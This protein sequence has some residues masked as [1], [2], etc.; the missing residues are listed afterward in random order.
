MRRLA[1]AA[2][3]LLATCVLPGEPSNHVVFAFAFTQP[4]RV[5]MGRPD[6]MRPHA[7]SPQISATANGEPLTNP[8]YRLESSNPSI[9]RVDSSGRGLQGVARGT[10]S[11]R[12]VLATALGAPDTT[13][14]V[15]VV[16]SHVTIEAPT[17]ILTK[18][19]QKDSLTAYASD[20][21]YRPVP[22]VTFTWASSRPGVG[23][24]SSAGLVTAVDEGNTMITAE[25]DGVTGSISLTVV[26]AAVRVQVSPKI[27][28]LRTSGRDRQFQAFAY[29][30]T[31]TR[32]LPV[33]VLWQSTVPAVATVDTAGRAIAQNAGTTKIIAKVGLVAD[34]AILVLK[35]VLRFVVVS[36]GLDTL[37]AIDDTSRFVAQALDSASIGI[38][39][40]PSVTWATADSAI[41]TV[42]QTGLVRARINGL[43]LVTA[44]SAGQPGSAVV[45]V[46]QEVSKAKISEDTLSLMG[47]GA[48]GR[49]TAAGVDRN[50]YPVPAAGTRFLWYSRLGLVATVDTGGLV[51]AHGDG[52]TTVLAQP[53]N[54]GAVDTATV[55]VTGAPQRLIAFDSP[56]GIEVVRV[57]GTLGT[58]LVNGNS[59][60]YYDTYMPQDPAWSVD[61][62]RVAYAAQYI[63]YYYGSYWSIKVSGVDGST[64]GEPYTASWFSSG[65]TWSPDGTKL[66][67]SSD[68][69]GSVASSIYTVPAA[70]GSVTNLTSSSTAHDYKPAWSPDGAKIAF[71]SNRDGNYEIYVMNV[72][73]SGVARLTND[74]GPDAEPAWSP[75]GSQLAFMRT[76][77][78][79]QD[80]WLMN[81]DGSGET[82]L[83][84]SATGPTVVDASPAW[85]PDGSQVVFASICS[86]CS[87]SDLYVINRDGTGLRR[88]TTNAGAGHPAWRTT[89]PLTPPQSGAAATPRRRRG[90]TR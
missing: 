44:S 14:D 24:I 73:G 74:P 67:F 89:A 65:P 69:A 27:D 4:Y 1:L 51:T 46:R 7:A 32:M 66:A 13:F 49:L 43:V 12:V 78:G 57:D 2:P 85:S 83:T 58:V 9:V 48:S 80:I 79:S 75:D 77:A 61:G 59:D 6:S 64:I 5:P 11:V 25:A 30:S 88:V 47:D 41:A 10:A 18:L 86:G 39:D 84:L 45:L 87:Q 16:V 37:T 36:P 33:K 70:G 35:Q 21:G 63:S 82:N 81:A 22:G 52:R 28:T 23:T 72:D 15:Q 71:Q 42:D 62:A 19:D 31:N 68:A 54:G 17:Q 90:P 50:G 53:I 34:T 8:P 55:L 40:L 60:Y 29:D 20:A 76:R 3:L 56:R 26:Q 38:P